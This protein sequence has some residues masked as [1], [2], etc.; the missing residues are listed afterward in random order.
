MVKICYENDSKTDEAVLM[1][2]LLLNHRIS[3]TFEEAL[4]SA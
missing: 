2:K 1:F 4:R 3:V